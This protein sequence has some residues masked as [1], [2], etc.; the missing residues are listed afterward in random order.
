LTFPTVF[1]LDEHNP[2][3]CWLIHPKKDLYMLSEGNKDAETERDRYIYDNS[4]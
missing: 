1:S 4:E 2:L 3:Y